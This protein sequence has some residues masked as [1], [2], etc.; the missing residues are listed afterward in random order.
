MTEEKKLQNIIK[1]LK[2]ENSKLR[3]ELRI[4]QKAHAASS[5]NN[6]FIKELTLKT[7]EIRTQNEEIRA[8]NEELV[9]TNEALKESEE[10]LSQILDE[11]VDAIIHS[12][13]TGQIFYA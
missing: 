1:E 4:A 9:A 6:N 5:G 12:D 7:E 2:S 3:E 10:H 13:K 8:I 11:S